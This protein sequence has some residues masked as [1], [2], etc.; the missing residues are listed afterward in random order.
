VVNFI[1]TRC[2]AT[3]PAQSRNLGNLQRQLRDSPHA[4]SIRLV[5]VSIDPEHD[6][7]QVL[8]E[9]A[10][11]QQARQSWHFLTGP[12]D[13]VRSLSEQGF[14]LPAGSSADGA[15]GPAHSSQ[16]ALV[17]KWGLIR[18]YYDGVAPEAVKTVARDLERLAA[19]TSP[20]ASLWAEATARPDPQHVFSHVL[21]PADWLPVRER[22]QRSQAE[23]WAEF[24]DFRFSDRLY[25]SGIRFRNRVVDDVAKDYKPMHYDHG[26]GLAVADV[27]GDG[28]TD[29]YFVNQVGP[30][31]LWRNAGGGRFENITERAGVA[32]AE[33]IKVTA[34]FADIN[35]DGSPDLYVTTVRG[36][37]E[38]FLNDGKGN[39][40]NAT[41]GSGLGLAGHYAGAV[42]F[43]YNRDGLLDLFLCDV[44]TFT[45][46]RQRQTTP[47]LLPPGGGEY[48]A[49]EYKYNEGLA[50]AFS[51]HLTPE[52][53]GQSRL[54]KNLGDAR[55]E[56]VTTEAGLDYTGWNGDATPLDGN[57]DGWPDL[58]ILNMQGNDEYFE[59]QAGERFVRKSRERFPKTPFGSMGAKVFDYNNDDV[60]DLLVTDMHSDMSTP[61]AADVDLE[62]RKSKVIWPD[63]FLGT[64]GRSIFGNA[65]FD[66]GAEFQE[67]SDQAGVENYWPWGPSVGDLNADGFADVFLTSGMG[68][69]YRY[70]T[71]SV[72]LNDG[73]GQFHDA[74]FVLGVE[75]RRGGR[76]AMPWFRLNA[77]GP[78]ARHPL[79]AG[80]SGQITVW[81][82]LSSRS[83]AVFDLDD[84]GDLDIVT[85]EFN[86]EPMLLVSNLSDRRKV[87]FLK[88]RL[89][90]SAAGADDS[91]LPT[92][93]SPG[94]PDRR[95]NRDGLGALVR[96]FYGGRSHLQVCDGK[97][98]HM[99]QSSLPL[100]FGLDEATEIEKVEVLWPSGHRQTIPGPI[101]ANELLTIEES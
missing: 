2:R 87:N 17:D 46:D 19:E 96:V 92:Q 36:G 38:L 30:S 47:P 28:L 12:V 15:A 31:E 54:L 41:E 9:Y 48:D 56:D 81:S 18:G 89:V 26:T 20:A 10:A 90:G 86:A 80:R 72:L 88:V 99:S 39:F 55:F 93:S 68:F 58:Y 62:K 37:N 67:V 59:N 21:G 57:S 29:I 24:H 4:D 52:R 98:G 100:Y 65:L 94:E 42:F 75:P 76:T 7:P 49:Q 73:G 27:D 6:T 33:P 43:D 97:S 3:C 85:N 69:P 11:A 63:S 14:K 22:D 91:A 78:G 61:L 34:S 79:A 51:G 70:G 8:S 60:I 83:S 77:S 1:F 23:H 50:D 40:R 84:D 44:G 64:G 74:E 13:D 95:S 45:G 53:F 35:N 71:N 5:S 25:A 16:F 82:S 66:G 101:A 32:L